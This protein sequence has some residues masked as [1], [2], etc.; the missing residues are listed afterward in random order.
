M[1]ADIVVLWGKWKRDIIESCFNDEEAR[2]I[3]CMPL[4]QFG[5]PDRIIWH[6]TRNWV[7]SIKSGYMMAQEINRNRELGRKCVGQSSRADTKDPVWMVLWQLKVPPK[8]C[9]FVW[10]GCKNILVVRTNLQCRGIC[11]EPSC[12]FYVD[13]VE[14]QVHLFFRCPFARIFWFGSPFQLDVTMIVGEDFLESWNWLCNKYGEEGEVGDLMRWVVCGG[15]GSVGIVWCFEKIDVKPSVALELLRQQW[16][17]IVGCK[18][19]HAQQPGRGQQ[20]RKESHERRIK[21]PFRTIK[22]NCDGA[23]C[24]CTGLGGF[25]RGFLM[26]LEVWEKF[27]MNQASWRR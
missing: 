7:Y 22:V 6:Y 23:W 14:T 8:F 11:L 20:V 24:T 4:S 27:Y 25:L 21:P 15:Y 2:I 12:P 3:L 17:E 19:E 10:K 9:H 5:C 1:V 13:D 16:G 26:V 18:G